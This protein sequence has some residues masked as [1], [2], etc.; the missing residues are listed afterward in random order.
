MGKRA[1]KIHALT[2]TKT[3]DSLWHTNNKNERSKKKTKTELNELS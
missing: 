2:P 1:L 3:V